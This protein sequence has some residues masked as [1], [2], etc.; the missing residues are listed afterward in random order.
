MRLTSL[1]LVLFFPVFFFPE[2]WF[3][4][5]PEA[6]Y[7]Y[8]RIGNPK[9]VRTI[10]AFGIALVGG[11]SDLDE[12]F[13]W[14]CNKGR[15]GDFLV[16][17]AAGDDDYN[18]YV[19]GLCKLNSIATLIIPSVEAAKDPKVADIIRNAEVIFIAG[20]DQSRYVNVW[21]GTPVEDALNAHIAADRP[22]GG[23]SA[24][25]AV[26]GEFVYAALGDAPD[27][28]DLASADVLP[29]PYHARVTLVRD[30]LKTPGLQNVITDTHFTKRDRMGR[31]LV[32]LARIMQDGWSKSP[33]EVAVDEKSAVL[34]DGNGKARVI[35]AGRGAYFIHPTQAPAVCSRN[36]PL[37]MSNISVYHAGSGA[38]FD[39]RAWHGEGGNAYS[40]SVERGVIHSTQPGGAVY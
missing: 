12:A 1:L 37:T 18:T 19:D 15:G 3:A 25:L 35:G 22:I 8:I 23:T 28:A 11:G 30:F 24:G 2:A 10:P 13:R 36:R 6:A 34:V 26:L 32:F 40:L 39:L 14:L 27:D 21:R 29:N 5:S 9:D 17:R 20:G 31:S 16:L 4:P 7:R 33:R 38:H